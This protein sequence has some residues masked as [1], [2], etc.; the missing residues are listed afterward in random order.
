MKKKLIFLTS[1]ILLSLLGCKTDRPD[2]MII[3]YELITDSDQPLAVFLDEDLIFESEKSKAIP[4]IFTDTLVIDQEGYS[5][6]SIHQESAN[7]YV[8]KGA[9]MKISADAKNLGTSL[10]FEGDLANENNYLASKRTLT[11]NNF[12]ELPSNEFDSEMKLLNEK[13]FKL[14]NDS[15]T[16]DTFKEK[17]EKELRYWA[18]T[19]RLLYPELHQRL[20]QETVVD[21]PSGFYLDL[22]NINFTDTLEYKNSQTGSY[23]SLVK[24]YFEWFGEKNKQQYQGDELLA[25]VSE[26]NN[27]FPKGS[28]KDD[29]LRYKLH[30]GMEVN[31][32]LEAVYEVYKHALQDKDLL[33][34]A[35]QEYNQL[36]KLIPGAPAPDFKLENY[37]GGM[38]SLNQLKGKPVFIDIWATWC[39]PCIAEFPALRDLAKEFTEVQFVSISVDQKIHFNTWRDVVERENLPGYQLIAYRSNEDFYQKYAV[40]TLPRYVVIDENGSII[41]AQAYRPTQPQLRELLKNL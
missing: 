21:L 28:V 22:E 19:Q 20:T 4:I 1:I 33:V 27:A 40:R 15:K 3:E 26:V 12:F 16:S 32:N 5:S 17:E 6:L 24:F 18:A 14:L 37:N 41:S 13:L 9:Q 8:R 2:Y 25:F 7:L 35:T 29:L 38:T 36:K 10:K 39:G 34:L 11:R 30:Y 23:I 31:G